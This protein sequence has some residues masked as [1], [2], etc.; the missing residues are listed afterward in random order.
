MAEMTRHSLTYPGI[1]EKLQTA[2]VVGP[3][4]LTPRK[5]AGNR[6]FPNVL[7]FAL[8]NEERWAQEKTAW[9]E[10]GVIDYSKQN[11]NGRYGVRRDLT[12]TEEAAIA[13]F[14]VQFSEEGNQM[15][16]YAAWTTND[17]PAVFASLA[18]PDA[19]MMY[20]TDY[21]SARTIQNGYFI[22]G[23]IYLYLHALEC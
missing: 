9:L 4:M 21:D 1:R 23:A 13:V 10:H 16:W 6:M 7:D 18:L 15:I 8:C 11:S 3:R 22:D 5:G 12:P 14:P 17:L 20:S 19:V 2:G